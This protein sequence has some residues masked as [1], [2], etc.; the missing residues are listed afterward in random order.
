MKELLLTSIG[1]LAPGVGQ[2]VIETQGTTQWRV[3]P[4]IRSICAVC[5]GG[6][7]QS[8]PGGGL[9]YRNNIPVT[10]GEILTIK[11]G[12]PQAGD[13]SYLDTQILRSDTVLLLA[14]HGRQGGLGGKQASEVNDGGG[15]GGRFGRRAGGG[16]GGYSGNGG[17]GSSV[18][19]TD[20]SP[21]QGGGGGGGG[22]YS[23]SQY[24]NGYGGG[25]GLLGEGPSGAG[26]TGGRTM[27][28]GGSGEPG[29]FGTETTYGG[30]G[31]LYNSGGSGPEQIGKPGVRIIWGEGR[32]YPN[33]LTEDL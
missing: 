32:A 15:N 21:G 17:D 6:G 2:V 13:R 25:V 18:N 23:S 28:N 14:Q 8:G 29:S 7:I 12:E 27:N 5:V 3:P 1:E 16:A 11:M 31:N 24:I 19:N 26:G 20:G 9:S 10:P 4:G 30:G 33:T 22:D